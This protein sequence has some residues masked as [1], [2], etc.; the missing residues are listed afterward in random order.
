MKFWKKKRFFN[1]QKGFTL[2]E[3]VTVLAI[4]GIIGLGATTATVQ[5]LTQTSKNNN[6]TTASRHTMNAGYWLSRDA[7][8]AQ[9]IDPGGVSGFPLTLSWTDWDNTAY[10]AAY[11][12][13]GDK[14]TRTYTVDGGNPS[15][16]LVAQYVNST[17]DNTSCDLTGGVLTLRVT[18]TVGEGTQE[19]SVTKV[20]EITSRPG[21]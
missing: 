12:I 8:M 11:A 1:G 15:E 5:L 4:T 14:L 21:L 9:D 10:Q 19:L 16:T 13:V 6:Y 7:Q 20:R 17:A 2:V 3:L 18:S